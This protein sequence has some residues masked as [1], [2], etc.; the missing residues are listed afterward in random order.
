MGAPLVHRLR[1]VPL[2]AAAWLAACASTPS[3]LPADT[4]MVGEVER[5]LTFEAIRSGSL[6]HPEE[7]RKFTD[8]QIARGRVFVVRTYLYWL[9]S[10]GSRYS[11]T[12]LA[13]APDALSLAPGNVVEMARGD[14][15]MPL[16][17]QR[18]RA[19]DLASGP[20]YY[21]E[22]PMDPLVNVFGWLSL[23]GPRGAA[24]LYCQGF[25]SEG[26]A[27]VDGLWQRLPGAVAAPAAAG[28]AASAPAVEAPPIEAL[29]TAAAQPA[30]AGDGL[31][32]LILARNDALAMAV[33][34]L[35]LS[36]DGKQVTTLRP[37][38]C[39]LV[40]LGPGRHI[41]EAG[42]AAMSDGWGFPRLS[43]ELHVTGG[44]SIVAEYS[45]DD[46]HWRRL[47]GDLNWL[48]TPR[49]VWGPQVFGFTQR[50]AGP[51]DRCTI[52]HAP[53]VLRSPAPAASGSR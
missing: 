11:A 40:L 42:T 53:S 34:D 6:R 46:R 19:A 44:E 41:V 13:L 50:P 49:S 28:S 24:S 2:L 7:A 48:W 45:V 20:C 38:Q 18:V 16:M 15:Q 21:S 27:R 37:G 9:S 17:V 5:A 8:D 22:V 35:P 14:E 29:S 12:V 52:G 26:W 3:S 4:L 30:G 23:T 32:Q 31:T 43:L 36:I 10:G 47:Y 39:D 33:F 25:E 51:R 1:F